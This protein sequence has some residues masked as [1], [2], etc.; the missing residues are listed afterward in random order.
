METSVA[1]NIQEQPYVGSYV[2]ESLTTGMYGASENALREYVQNAFDS[3]RSAIQLKMIDAETA[4]IDVLLTGRDQISITDNG[5]GIAVP[6]VFR[7]LTSVG[8][9]K[10]DR[11]KQAG[12]RGIGRLAGIAFCDTLTFRTKAKDEE[13]ESVL[14]FDCRKLRKGMN[15]GSSQLV[16]LLA[17]SVTHSTKLS[18][19][20]SSHYMEVTLLGLTS[21]PDIFRDAEQLREYLSE[22]SPV[23]FNPSWPDA[24]SII[25]AAKQSKWTL[26]TAQL[27]LG[28]S[29]STLKPIYKL[30]KGSYPLTGTNSQNIVKLE[31][32][33]GADNQW[34]A[35]VGH[36][37]LTQLIPDPF[38]RGLR[39]RVK[40]I[41]VGG[42]TIFDDIFAAVNKSFSRLNGYY[43]GEVHISSAL[44]V[45]N[46]R[47]D[48]FEDSPAWR[49]IRKEL[50]E[51]LCRPLA[52]SAYDLSKGRQKSLEKIEQDVKK[53]VS[54]TER[55]ARGSDNSDA[56]IKALNSG[57]NL[58]ARIT[59][60]LEEALPETQL[61][62]KAQMQIINTAQKVL[63]KDSDG[64]SCKA[65]V[66]QAIE[67]VLLLLQNYLGP[68]EYR[69]V[70]KMIKATVKAPA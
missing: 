55:A 9:S 19:K 10:K 13:L 61:R 45:P 41:Q 25:E 29:T 34:W 58:R 37:N 18:T 59:S 42:T 62:L 68:N 26:E 69:E 1:E 22:T 64:S 43:V 27:Y 3:V 4:R 47:R 14:S 49:K 21:A 6:A 39:A 48:G 40:N 32:V 7:T 8:A 35:W 56:R 38:V 30:Y 67:Q 66:E 65:A 53:L 60:A 23:A 54:S 33:M 63:T 31:Y 5:V 17:S 51:K 15:D 28:T 24:K 16:E 50:Q 2:L 36:P 46:A 57:A 11:Q 70:S 12:F 52:R 20:K 44:L